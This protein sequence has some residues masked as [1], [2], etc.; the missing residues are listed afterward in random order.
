M[1]NHILTGYVN[2]HDFQDMIKDGNSETEIV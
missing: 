2:L 1:L